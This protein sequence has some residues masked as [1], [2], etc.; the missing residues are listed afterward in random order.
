MIFD[1]QKASMLKR[2]S[3]FLLDIILVAILAV[4]VMYLMSVVTNYDQH[5]K[6]ATEIIETY[7]KRYEEQY[8]VDFD[9]KEEVYEALSKEEKDN[10][11]AAVE[12][13]NKAFAED[14]EAQGV[15]ITAMTLMYTI[16]SVGLLVGVL[17]VEF[18]IPLILKNGQ[19]IGKKVFN[20]GVV[21]NN[22]VRVTPFA[23]FARSLLGK[24]TIEL[25]VPVLVIIALLQGALNA[26]IAMVVLVGLVVLQIVVYVRSQ[27]NCFIHDVLANTVVVDMATQMIFDDEEKLIDYKIDLSRQQTNNQIY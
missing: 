11:L 16:T 17:V 26:L 10:Y 20:L 18:I 14:D 4:G 23:M 3:A 27:N 7:T 19:T 22:S 2:I 21:F 5:S 24:Y 8:G 1:V 12:A 25:M 9:I 15:Y 13:M 6:K